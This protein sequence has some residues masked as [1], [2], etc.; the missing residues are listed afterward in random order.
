MS[1]R[2]R[3]DIIPEK[4]K[5]I[6]IG[7]SQY[8]YPQDF[9]NIAPVEGNIRDLN[10]VFSNGSICGIKNIVQILNK[11]SHEIQKEFAKESS[12]I[13][14]TLLV[15]YTGHGHRANGKK[16]FLTGKDSQKEYLKETCINFETIYERCER[17]NA[18]KK[19]IFL[20]A[21]V[22]LLLKVEVAHLLRNWN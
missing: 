21:T 16:L 12:D 2:R 19:I 7:T 10:N 8:D 18:Q 4:S 3:L 9:P 22:A 20:V 17:S 5:V 14:D 11:D 15:Y 6:L 13:E 1:T